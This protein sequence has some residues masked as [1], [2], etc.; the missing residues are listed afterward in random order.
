ML[1]QTQVETVIPYYERF[2]ERFVAGA[3]ALQ[4]GDPLDPGTDQ[5]AVVSA[6]HRDNQIDLQ[7]RGERSASFGRLAA[8][9]ETLARR[10]GE[11]PLDELRPYRAAA[12]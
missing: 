12:E 4:V 5:G 10:L 7:R 11:I 1:Q 8:D 2:L 9:L 6:A 3:R